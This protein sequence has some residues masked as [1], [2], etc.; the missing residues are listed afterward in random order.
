MKV[1]FVDREIPVISDIHVDKDFGTGCVKVTPAHDPNDFAI[2]KRNNLKQINI[3][4]PRYL[5]RLF[6]I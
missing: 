1:P 5:S 6:Y 4:K 2:G 3:K